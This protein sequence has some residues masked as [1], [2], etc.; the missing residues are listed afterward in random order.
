MSLFW[1]GKNSTWVTSSCDVPRESVALASL[2]PD[3]SMPKFG[4]ERDSHK[5]DWISNWKFA[6][7]IS[8]ESTLK[9]WF[10][11]QYIQHAPLVATESRTLTLSQRAANR[12]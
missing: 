4:L 5:E 1:L 3:I 6:C 11:G 12:R 10:D 9:R 8:D 2:F 7:P